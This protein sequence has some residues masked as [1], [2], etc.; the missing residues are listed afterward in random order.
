MLRDGLSGGQVKYSDT[1][2]SAGSVCAGTVS[3]CETS[4]RPGHALPDERL[5][6]DSTIASCKKSQ[7]T[8]TFYSH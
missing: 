2:P 7:N 4:R 6:R 5:Y 1:D 3:A 8:V